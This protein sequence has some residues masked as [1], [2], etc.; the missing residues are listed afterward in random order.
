[1]LQRLGV[2]SVTPRVA[3]AGDGRTSRCTLHYLPSTSFSLL[4]HACLASSVCMWL[5]S[6]SHACAKGQT[7]AKDK[8]SVC[9][10]VCVL[11]S[12]SGISRQTPRG[13]SRRHVSSPLWE[14]SVVYQLLLFLAYRSHH[15]CRLN[16]VVV[17]KDIQL[18]GLKSLNSF[19]YSCTTIVD[20]IDNIHGRRLSG[21]PLDHR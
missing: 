18:V 6:H 21:S 5:Y 2:A 13:P 15:T 1:M 10:C 9:V 12:K 4:I 11:C 3:P 19:G 7:Q 8:G 16:I 17:L 14:S 20:S